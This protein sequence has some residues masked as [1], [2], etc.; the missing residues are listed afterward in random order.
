MGYNYITNRLEQRHEEANQWFDIPIL[1]GIAVG[2][3]S[4]ILLLTGVHGLSST[5]TMQRWPD[6]THDKNIQVPQ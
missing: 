5:Q 4:I 6:S 3:F 1:M 2:V